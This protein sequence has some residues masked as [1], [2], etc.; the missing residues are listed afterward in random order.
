MN[1]YKRIT[2]GSLFTINVK[3]CLCVLNEAYNYSILL[4]IK[5]NRVKYNLYRF[6]RHRYNEINI[7]N[8]RITY[9][10]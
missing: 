7:V 4:I 2:E 9:K 1:R 3:I 6:H 10:F 8:E 5:Y